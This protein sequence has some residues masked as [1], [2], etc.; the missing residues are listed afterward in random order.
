MTTMI[1][2]AGCG[3]RLRPLTDVV[4]KA[5]VPVGGKPLLQ[6]VLESV[7]GDRVVINIHHHAD[8]IRNFI[9]TTREHWKAEI[10]LSDESEALLDTGGGLR[11]A[12]PLLM[13]GVLSSTRD[14]GGTRDDAN[15]EPVLIH[16]VD[17]L[18]NVDLD[19]L[20]QEGKRHDATLV[21][22][23]RETSRYLVFNA[24]GRLVGWTN[25]KTGEV[26]GE[27]PREGCKLLAFAG[28]HVI[29]PRLLRLMQSWPEK[30]SVIDFY[31]A[32]CR[33]YDIHAYTPQGLRILDVGKLDTLRAADTFLSDN[34]K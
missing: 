28:I 30:F 25:I 4:P 6:R 8:Q 5:L 29:S 1:F 33:D 19:R 12:A 17:I 18:S 3:T 13:G 24:E 21:V 23:Q 11:K 22:S 31:L 26:K 32:V 27:L 34:R 15:D 2:A 14:M 10:L 16:N 7:G 20:R 9:Q